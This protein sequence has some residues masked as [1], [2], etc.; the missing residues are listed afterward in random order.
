MLYNSPDSA[1]ELFSVPVSRITINAAKQIKFTMQG[2][3]I[4]GKAR[5]AELFR[6]SGSVTN[7]ASELISKRDFQ[8][9]K[10]FRDSANSG[11]KVINMLLHN[12]IFSDESLFMMGDNK[13][14]PEALQMQ[15]EGYIAF[16]IHASGYVMKIDQPDFAITTIRAVRSTQEYD[17]LDV[18][19]EVVAF[20]SA[21]P[22][23]PLPQVGQHP[24]IN[25]AEGITYAS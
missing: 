15:C 5:W 24:D 25:I 14:C 7:V 3:E 23:L 10:L 4:S 2:R 18:A 19:V 21:I 12:A 9:V 8:S 1:V 17:R 13:M 6:T 11:F 22:L 20:D 16:G